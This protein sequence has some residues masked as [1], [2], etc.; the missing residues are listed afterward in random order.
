MTIRTRIKS[1]TEPVS[2]ADAER[3][4]R[5][6]AVL[7]L[8]QR[9]RKNDI[10]AAI[11]A[12]KERHSARLA[13]IAAEVKDKAALV[14]TYAEANP[15]DFGKL[16][17]LRF[18][19]GTIGFRTGTPKLKTLSGW[20]FDRVLA[21]LKEVLWG[22][23]FIRIHEEVDKEE[24]ISGF[25]QGMLTADELREIGTRVVQDET[26]FVEPDLAAVEA[27]IKEAA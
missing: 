1:K 24:L 13:E 11:L 25:G 4:V 6:I 20:T 14:Q 17:S 18:E 23:A 16:K 26:F 5:D 8:E 10:D 21:K 12:A 2:R 27:R 9:D 3:I 15:E 19:V 7:T 22:A